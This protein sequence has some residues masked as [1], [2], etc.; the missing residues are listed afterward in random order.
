M[1]DAPNDPRQHRRPHTPPMAAPFLEFDLNR[2]LEQLHAEPAWAAGQ[3]ARTLV[4]FDD[5][6]VVLMTL[7][8]RAQVPG[9]QTKGRIS[10]HTLVGHILVRAEGRTFDL[11][12]GGVLALDRG[13]PHD[14]EA[15][16][17]SAFLLS[18][19]WPG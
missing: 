11:P 2:E 4:K 15:L 8:A 6:R 17:D 9:H 14:V 7:R 19:A 3:N 1:S 13:V 12:G 18:I 5:F 16:E 10:I